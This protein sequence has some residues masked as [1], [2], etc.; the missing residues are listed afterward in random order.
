M[1]RSIRAALA[2]TLLWAS[3]C[4]D[5]PEPVRVGR[6]VAFTTEDPSKSLCLGAPAR[7]DRHVEQVHKFIGEPVPEGLQV[8]LRVVEESI[9]PTNA[10]YSNA[11]RTIYVEKLDREGRFPN[12]TVEHELTHALIDRAW[13]TSVPSLTE[14]MAE[15]LTSHDWRSPQPAAPV[16][17]M[18]DQTSEALDYAELGRF[19]RFLV[20]SGGIERFKRLYQA[21]RTRSRPAIEANFKDVYGEHF[22]AIEARYLSGARR[23]RFQLDACDD[24]TAE[25]VAAYWTETFA[26]SCL[27][28]DFYGS[29]SD[30]FERFATQRTLRIEVDG[31]Y[32]LR[33]SIPRLL[34]PSGFWFNAE[35]LLVRCGDCDEQR[36]RRV[37]GEGVFSLGPGL[38]TIL[39]HQ[40]GD[41]VVTMELELID[42]AP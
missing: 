42:E 38:Y 39:L 13:G 7:L 33:T 22:E 35:V 10:C 23:C 24:S 9:C 20:D 19:V 16:R 34:E 36:V 41:S 14:G 31:L 40:R 26:A 12:S 17:A 15:A 30:E 4:D 3:A 6:F 27:D 2:L 32:R 21:S 25:S 1:A 5:E 28:P 11:S 37:Q 8:P 18:L 29:R